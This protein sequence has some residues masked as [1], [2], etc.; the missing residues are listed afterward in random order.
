MTAPGVSTL[1]GP[2]VELGCCPPHA[3]LEIGTCPKKTEE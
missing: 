2:F 1:P 3:L